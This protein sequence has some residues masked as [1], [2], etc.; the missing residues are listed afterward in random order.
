MKRETQ[1]PLEQ[2][3]AFVATTRPV[4]ASGDRF[5]TAFT[6]EALEDMGRQ[7]EEGCVWLDV[8]HLAFMPPSGRWRGAELRVGA[9]GESELFFRGIELPQRVATAELMETLASLPEGLPES[10]VSE[11]STQ[12]A[13]ER[14]NFAPEVA[15]QIHSEGP[16]LV[17]QYERWSD[18]PPLEFILAIPVTWGASQFAGAFLKELGRAAGAG[19]A[20]RIGSW[21]RR[22]KQPDRTAVFTLHFDLPNGASVSGYAFAEPGEVETQVNRSLMASEELASIAAAVSELN[23]LPGLKRAAYFLD[24]DTWRLGWWSDGD[25]VTRTQWFDAHPP[26]INGVL[27][28]APTDDN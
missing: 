16:G 7:V 15:S 28:H 12:L 5:S 11:L 26:D 14:R 19:L 9:D 10:Q 3:E 22:S 4:R 13:F 1:P 8:E 18:L 25:Q 6:R 20:A 23:L 27:G 24:G 17:T 21:S 2:F